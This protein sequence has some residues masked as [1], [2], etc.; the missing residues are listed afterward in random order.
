MWREHLG[1]GGDTDRLKIGERGGPAA[2]RSLHAAVCHLSVVQHVMHLAER[3]GE[4]ELTPS[5][6]DPEGS[7]AAAARRDSRRAVPAATPI[8][9]WVHLDATSYTSGCTLRAQPLSGVN[10]TSCSCRARSRSESG[11]GIYLRAHTPNS[12]PLGIVVDPVLPACTDWPSCDA[13]YANP[14]VR[15]GGAR[16]ARC[17]SLRRGACDAPP[18]QVDYPSH[19][20]SRTASDP[21]AT[22]STRRQMA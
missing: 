18:A 13:F 1:G 6:R 9:I 17:A 12:A 19:L 10:R 15:F 11:A 21:R 14:R 5:S 4:T 16:T 20:C 2:H 3:R 7:C 22:P 8:Q